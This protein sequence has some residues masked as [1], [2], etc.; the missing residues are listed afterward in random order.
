[1]ILRIKDFPFCRDIVLSVPSATHFLDFP[2]LATETD[3]SLLCRLLH[4]LLQKTWYYHASE[5]R[6][7]EERRTDKDTAYHLQTF[8]PAFLGSALPYDGLVEMDMPQVAA[9]W[10]FSADT[11]TCRVSCRFPNDPDAFPAVILP[12]VPLHAVYP[13]ISTLCDPL[14]HEWHAAPASWLSLCASLRCPLLQEAWFQEYLPQFVPVIAACDALVGGR[15]L[16]RQGRFVIVN[17]RRRPVGEAALLSPLQAA[18]AMWALLLRNGEI[19]DDTWV[20]HD[21][22]SVGL[23][24]D[25]AFRFRQILQQTAHAMRGTGIIFC[26]T[27]A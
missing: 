26:R 8:L 1:M 2:S 13:D 25:D 6:Q 14:R 23:Y 11:G 12:S 10:R 15:M 9:S 18:C 21:L 3:W 19:N 24:E 17:E 20:F 22:C 16:L 5:G 27:S 7:G 4:A